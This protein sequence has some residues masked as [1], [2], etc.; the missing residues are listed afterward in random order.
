MRG[1]PVIWKKKL[2]INAHRMVIPLLN[3]A[4][5]VSGGALWLKCGTKALKKALWGRVDM[6][7]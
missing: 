5:V 2:F 6:E 1:A 3:L 4:I 7:C